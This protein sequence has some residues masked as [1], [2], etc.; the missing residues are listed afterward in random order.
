MEKR[1]MSAEL[2]TYDWLGRI[3]DLFGVLAG[4][5]LAW[6]VVESSPWS[7]P[8]FTGFTGDIRDLLLLAM[9]MHSIHFLSFKEYGFMKR[10]GVHV[11]LNFVSGSIV[12]LLFRLFASGN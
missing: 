11:L 1:V 5:I 10:G 3:I 2:A 7:S 4:A 6:I 12:L 8:D 9:L